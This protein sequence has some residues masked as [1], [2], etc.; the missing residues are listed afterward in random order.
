LVFGDDFFEELVID[1]EVFGGETFDLAV[2]A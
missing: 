1:G 2:E